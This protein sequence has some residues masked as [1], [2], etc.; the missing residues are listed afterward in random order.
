MGQAKAKRLSDEIRHKTAHERYDKALKLGESQLWV[1]GTD[2]K[3]RPV[4]SNLGTG[5]VLTRGKGVGE[6][7]SVKSITHGSN[8]IEGKQ[9]WTLEGSGEGKGLDRLGILNNIPREQQQLLSW[10]V[11]SD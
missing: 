8:D 4:I 5:R 1:L 11:N 7:V 3:D 6:V 2:S 10:R 9:N